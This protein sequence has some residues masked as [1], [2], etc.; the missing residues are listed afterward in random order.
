MADT[1]SASKPNVA[2]WV[3][4]GMAEARAGR[5]MVARRAFEEA[6]SLDPRCKEALLWLAALAPDGET[7]LRHLSRVLEIDPAEPRAHAGIRWA[8]KRL[9]TRPVSGQQPAQPAKPVALS[10]DTQPSPTLSA[11]LSA[12][13][14]PAPRIQVQHVEPAVPSRRLR[15]WRAWAAVALFACLVVAAGLLVFDSAS[16]GQVSA[17]LALITPTPTAT[18]TATPSQ[19]PTIAPSDTPTFTATPT[20]PPPTETATATETPLPP[21]DTPMPL[22]T[23]TPYVPPPPTADLPPVGGDLSSRWI[24]VNLS[25]QSVIAYDGDTP[26]RYMLASTGLPNTPTVTGQFRVYLR[27]D[28]QTMSGPGYYLPGVQWV[29]YFYQGYALHGTYW[30]NNFGQPMSHGCVNLT[31]TDAAWLWTWADYGTLVQVHY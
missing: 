29:Q 25:A 10:D 5:A 1:H 23:S 7:S 8:R 19:T 6:L 13:T 24:D 4:R 3:R 22:P 31:N 16:G 28:S 2:E 21:T 27:Y 15:T 11:R 30:H 9:R 18:P 12:D 20:S 17:A 26:V 14:Q